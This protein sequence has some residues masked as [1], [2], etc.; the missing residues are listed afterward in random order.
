MQIAID[1]VNHYLKTSVQSVSHSLLFIFQNN[2]EQKNLSE[3]KKRLNSFFPQR[4]AGNETLSKSFE[5]W[6]S[7]Q[8]ES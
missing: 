7:C 5:T 1:F 3:H 6:L 2:Q 8:K 4:E